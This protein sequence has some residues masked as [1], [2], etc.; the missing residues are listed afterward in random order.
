MGLEIWRFQDSEAGGHS[1]SDQ[2]GNQSI[3]VKR[4][5]C[6]LQELSAGFSAIVADGRDRPTHFASICVVIPLRW[7]PARIEI[8][9]QEELKLWG[10][11]RMTIKREISNWRF[12][13][14]PQRLMG[15]AAVWRGPAEETSSAGLDRLHQKV[16]KY[17]H[18]FWR[19]LNEFLLLFL[20]P[21]S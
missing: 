15:G 6:V 11:H 8:M 10:K 17:R 12:S 4:R 9:W 3:N 7:M 16:P 21:L 13:S 18:W 5:Q 1:I 2:Q 20:L 19:I 14:I